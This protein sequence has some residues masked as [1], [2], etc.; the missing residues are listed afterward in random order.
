MS[1]PRRVSGVSIAG[2]TDSVPYSAGLA[3]YSNWELSS[4]RANAARRALVAGHLSEEKLLQ[5]RGLA[6]VLPLDHGTTDSPLNRRI[7]ILVMNKAAERAFFEQ[8]KRYDVDPPQKAA[9]P[10]SQG[11]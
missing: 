2:H 7:S 3:G 8:A 9:T 10:A 5:V 1:P 11:S 4:E 6:D